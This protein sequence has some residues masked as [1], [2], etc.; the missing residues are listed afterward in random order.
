MA[1]EEQG[2]A[3]EAAKE[4]EAA[5]AAMSTKV[6]ML[7][8]AGMPTALLV[9]VA[10]LSVPGIQKRF[11]DDTDAEALAKA[12]VSYQLLKAQTEALAAQA[13]ETRSEVQALRDLIT[14]LL[15]QHAGAGRSIASVPQMP[16]PQPVPVLRPLP[17]NLDVAAA[18]VM[19]VQ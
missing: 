16:E 12:E 3:V 11:F 19:E 10:L 1:T 7:K 4:V 5:V 6:S 8:K 9:V 15:M 17:E 13:K 14:Q 2:Q 18:A